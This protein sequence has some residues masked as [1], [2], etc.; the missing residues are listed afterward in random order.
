[1]GGTIDAQDVDLLFFEQ[2]PGHDAA[3]FTLAMASRRA[4]PILRA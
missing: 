1:M 4:Q 3:I 2:L